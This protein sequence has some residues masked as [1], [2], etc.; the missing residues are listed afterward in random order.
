MNYIQVRYYFAFKIVLPLLD[1]LSGSG[2]LIS[3]R[4]FVV[5]W[6]EKV[7]AETMEWKLAKELE[8]GK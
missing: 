1:L 8:Q 7:L 5:L 3:A 6:A 2:M 4:Q